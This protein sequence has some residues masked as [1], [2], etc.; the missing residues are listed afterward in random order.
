MDEL[1]GKHCSACAGAE[2]LLSK[3][4]C[5]SYLRQLDPAWAISE[6]GS[7]LTRMF[8]FKGFAKATYTANLC[9]FIADREGHHPD[10]SF[11]WGYCDVRLTTHEA[12]GLTENDFIWAKRLDEALA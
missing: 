4:Q 2:G 11:G 5:A 10:V 3:E 7:Q 8:R 12:G 9:A 6:D 1:S